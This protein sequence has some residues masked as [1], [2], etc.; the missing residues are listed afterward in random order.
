M[1]VLLVTRKCGCLDLF[2]LPFGILKMGF[3]FS[4]PVIDASLLDV[5][6]LLHALAQPDVFLLVLSSVHLDLPLAVQALTCIGF[7]ILASGFIGFS[8]LASDSSNLGSATLL[9]SLHVEFTMFVLGS[10]LFG[11]LL[12]LHSMAYLDLPMLA[13]DATLLDLFL[14][15]RALT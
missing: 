5:P 6:L 9:R 15:L 3:C 2:L 12:S 4:L 7:S 14:L 10:A 1:G 11:L 8:V 13:V